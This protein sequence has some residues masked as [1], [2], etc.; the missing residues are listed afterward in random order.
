MKTQYRKINF[1]P[2]LMHITM[3][4]KNVITIKAKFNKMSKRKGEKFD[5]FIQ[6]LYCL[7]DDFE[8]KGLKEKLIRDRI[9][10]EVSD[11]D[12]SEKLL[13]LADLSGKNAS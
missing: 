8:Y 12:L 10:A 5:Y 6:D 13:N 2:S 9:V 3:L 4:G 11:N 7:A 1:W